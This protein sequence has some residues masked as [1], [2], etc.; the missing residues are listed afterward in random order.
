[1]A[2]ILYG[3]LKKANTL[4]IVFSNNVKNSTLGNISI[5]LKVKELENVLKQWHQGKFTFMGK[6]VVIRTFALPRPL[7]ALSTADMSILEKDNA[8]VYLERKT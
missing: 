8:N 2:R 4:G 3:L 7:T 1:M 6:V 5:Q